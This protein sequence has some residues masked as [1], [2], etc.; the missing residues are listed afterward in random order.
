M[1]H[2]LIVALGIKVIFI[3]AFL[4]PT[5]G[6]YYDNT[7]II[8]LNLQPYCDPNEKLYHEM[9]HAAFLHDQE[10]RSFIKKYPAPKYY[11]TAQYPTADS[12]LDEKVADYFVMYVKYPDFGVKFPEIKRLFDK[13]VHNIIQQSLLSQ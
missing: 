1:I 11:Y 12:R 2:A 4:S 5:C 3:E 6:S 13:K 10:V 9:G 7:K 8:T